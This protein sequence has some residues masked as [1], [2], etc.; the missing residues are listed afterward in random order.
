MSNAFIRSNMWPNKGLEKKV[1]PS[2]PEFPE[3]NPKM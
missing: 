2:L 3:K 1:E